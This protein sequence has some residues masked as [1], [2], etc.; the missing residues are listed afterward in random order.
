MGMPLRM[1]LDT[2][3]HGDIIPT[4]PVALFVLIFMLAVGL[5][6]RH[7]R[8]LRHIR[9]GPLPPGLY[10]K[11]RARRSDIDP[12]HFP[13]LEQGLR[14]FFEAYLRSGRKPVSM[15]S[16]AVDELWHEFILHTRHYQQFCDRAFGR[17][18]HHSPA[19]VLSKKYDRNVGLRRVWWHCCKREGI[20]PRNAHRLPLLFALDTQLVLADGFHYLTDCRGLRRQDDNHSAGCGSGPQCA[21]DMSDTSFDGT[22]D[23]FGDSGS[24]SGSSSGDGDGGSDGGGGCGGD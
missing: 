21:T 10:D 9:H 8:R 12:I 4:V 22:T 24:D 6:L 13:R 19:A 2:L 15:P 16:Q 23:G 1:S 11:L 20:D 18:L 14:D 3:I 17:F 5:R 7:Q